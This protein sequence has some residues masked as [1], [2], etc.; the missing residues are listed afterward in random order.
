M[1]T[2][3]YHVLSANLKT[4][5]Q[6]DLETRTFSVVS[7]NEAF[8]LSKRKHAKALGKLW[9]G[10]PFWTPRRWWKILRP[11][12]SPRWRNSWI[13]QSMTEFGR[14]FCPELGQM[15]PQHANWTGKDC[16]TCEADLRL[17]LCLSVLVGLRY[18][19]KVFQHILTGS[20]MVWDWRSSVV[21]QRRRAGVDLCY[22]SRLLC[23]DEI[24]VLT[25]K[26]LNDLNLNVCFK[27][28]YPL[29]LALPEWLGMTGSSKCCAVLIVLSLFSSQDSLVVSD[30]SVQGERRTTP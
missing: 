23:R 8:V 21:L 2:E 27:H 7:V 14:K 1:H 24:N 11:L 29:H 9:Q 15:F 3:F 22:Y 26:R 13:L 19:C 12:K 5:K 6:Q 4:V 20:E 16:Q 28:F 10:F 17:C 30:K 25:R 18:A